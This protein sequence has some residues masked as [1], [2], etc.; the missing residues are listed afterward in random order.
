MTKGAVIEIDAKSEARIGMTSEQQ[1]KEVVTLRDLKTTMRD[2][3]IPLG[4]VP[5][6]LPTTVSVTQNTMT[7]NAGADDIDDPLSRFLADFPAAI[8]LVLAGLD[9]AMEQ[10]LELGDG[11]G[12]HRMGAQEA[13]ADG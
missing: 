4:L 13:D 10:S 11:I 8:P 12:T 6:A 3:Q 1:R 2:T 5:G 7:I 9:R